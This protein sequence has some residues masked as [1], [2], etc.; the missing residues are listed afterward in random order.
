MKA[1]KKKNRIKQVFIHI[2]LLVQEYAK[3]GEGNY[4]FFLSEKIPTQ[5][6]ENHNEMH[7]Q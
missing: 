6:W 4:Q 3:L 2:T 5:Y 1:R 7:L